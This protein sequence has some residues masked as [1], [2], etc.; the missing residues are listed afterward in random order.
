LAVSLKLKQITPSLFK[1]NNL[2][3]FDTVRDHTSIL[4]WNTNNNC[5]HSGEK[6]ETIMSSDEEGQEQEQESGIILL[7]FFQVATPSI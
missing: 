2:V 5:E 7:G 1:K 6:E 3:A 4:Y